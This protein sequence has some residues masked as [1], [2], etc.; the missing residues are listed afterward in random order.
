LGAICHFIIG[1]STNPCNFILDVVV[2]IIK[3]AMSTRAAENFDQE[4]EYDSS[5]SAI[6]HQLPTSLYTALSR[7]KIEGR[8]TLFATCPS[9]NFTHAPSYDRASA[10]PCYPTHCANKIMRDD[11]SVVC[12]T[13]LLEERNGRPRPIKPYLVA[14]FPDYLARSLADTEYERLSNQTC[15][16]AKANLNNPPGDMADIY[17]AAFMKSFEGPIPGQLFIDRGDKMRL[18]FAIHVDFFNPN[19]TRKRGNHD[20]IGI[21]SLVNLNLPES[22]RYDPE[23]IYLAGVVPGPHEPCLEQI[24]HFIRPIID[25]FEIGWHR[26][27]RISRTASR[28]EGVVV[29]VAI[30][31]SINDF[32]A[33]RKVS[34]NISQQSHHFCTVCCSYGRCNLNNTDFTNW[35]MRDKAAMRQQAEA[36][37][38]AK[39]IEE[40][41]TI[42]TTHGVRWSE[43]W[44]L[45]YWDPP[46]M[47]VIDSMHCILEGVVHYHC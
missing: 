43:F 39:T 35:K 1:L 16:D 8:T 19:G 38:D 25:E 36:W 11:N 20:S 9:C 15:D 24:N 21:I 32:P 3:L 34:G 29:E 22:I 27:F 41:N 26:G 44:R 2:M 37:R 46:R 17:Q 5:Q 42:F 33:A 45:P 7:L 14:S 30:A 6:L 13:E 18:A 47:L 23:N 12:G 40:R 31:L 28:A 10:T 4:H